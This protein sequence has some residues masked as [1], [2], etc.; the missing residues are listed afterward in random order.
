MAS[1]DKKNIL[2]LSPSFFSYEVEIQDALKRKGAHVTWC[3]E[4][5]SN[6]F[7]TKVL[8]RL[9]KKAVKRKIINY[10]SGILNQLIK[11]KKE[12]DY[13]FI[14]SPETLTL[15]IL[16]NFKSSFPKAEVIL[17][18][19]DSFKNK[20]ALELLPEVDR[21]ITFD[22]KDA[23]KY[24]LKFRPL[25][26]IDKYKAK[27]AKILYDLLFIATAH[28]DRYIFVKN[29]MRKLPDKLR[30]KSY[31]F[32]SSQ[33][34]YWAKKIVEKNFKNV[35]LEDISFTSLSHDETAEMVHHTKVVLDINH[36]EQVGLTMR[37]LETLGAQKK[38][39]TTNKDIV[40][41]DFYNPTNFLILDRNDPNLPISF[42][43]TTFKP[44]DDDI[45]KKY[46]VNGWI[47]EIF[48]VD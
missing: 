27:E 12:F 22:P 18:M 11:E 46:C 2:F 7:L 47:E 8:I 9:N 26:Y 41:Y 37:T 30:F 20:G 39:I 34:L 24:D 48:E 10:Y 43:N 28:S 25:F 42:F 14:I 6:T 44:V 16:T 5:P 33:K 36:P 3:D 35:K 31:F 13:I 29:L 19:W 32:L 4:R 1:L 21:T 23:E 38:L 15:P 45:L 17:Y 40:R